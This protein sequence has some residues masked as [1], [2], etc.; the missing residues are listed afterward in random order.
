MPRRDDIESILLI[1]SGPME[2]ELADGI[3]R[4][5]LSNV[6]RLEGPKPQ[7]ELISRMAD[8]E[9]AV[10]PC[11]VSE[12]GD[13]DGLP[14]VL[15]EA[16]ARALPV[17]TTT[18]SGGPEIV[19]D[20]LTGRLCAPGDPVALA[21][22]LESLLSDRVAACAMGLAGRARAERLFDLTVNAARL[23]AMLLDPL[24]ARE[25]A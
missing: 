1:G 21:D 17:V 7:E 4:L 23:R 15:L 6:V 8:A 16:M 19:E 22:A 2:A 11:V 20:G 9:V 18:V 13:R 3:M 12:S 5:D 10:L 25:A 24:S 14:T